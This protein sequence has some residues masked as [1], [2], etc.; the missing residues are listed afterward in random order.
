M[1]FLQSSIVDPRLKYFVNSGDSDRGE[2]KKQQRE[3]V[4]L[5]NIGLLM[6][7]KERE[8]EISQSRFNLIH[9]F[10]LFS[11]L[12][13]R[14]SKKI[15]PLAQNKQHCL[16]ST[17]YTITQTFVFISPRAVDYKNYL[18]KIN[19]RKFTPRRNKTQHLKNSSI[20]LI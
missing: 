5:I 1:H 16:P 20:L 9:L 6:Q 11:I 7:R 13:L 18:L 12:P 19:V 14:D 4:Y 17:N 10:L 3:F 8:S 2:E 15:S